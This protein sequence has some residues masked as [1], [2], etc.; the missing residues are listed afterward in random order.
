MTRR[1]LRLAL[2]AALVVV[3]VSAFAQTGTVIDWG[4]DCYAWE[5]GYNPVTHISAP[6]SQ[7]S[8]VGIVNQFVGP[9]GSI[10]PNTPG[11]EYTFYIS[12]FT[13]A[14]GT[15]I[16]AGGTLSVYTT[17]YSGGTITIWQNSPRNAA[18]GTNPPNGTVPSTFTDGTLFLSGTIPSLKVAVTRFNSNGNWLSGNADSG[19]PPNGTWTGGSALESVS[20]GG[21][22]CPWRLTGGWDM[23]PSDV[24]A[25]YTTQFDG[26]IDLNCPT[27]ATSSTWGAI[28][29]QY[30]D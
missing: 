18:F 21:H 26:K 12:G 30:R 9:L 13:T 14:A 5:T 3:P 25:G 15:A 10:N 2:T 17:N 27:A 19:D 22:P 1:L 29:S 7:M 23:K 8:I 20:A 28:K 11:T 4:P 16:S 6:G 24:L